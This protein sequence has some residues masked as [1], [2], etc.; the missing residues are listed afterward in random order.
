[1]RQ[2]PFGNQQV[3]ELALGTWGLA[4]DGYGPVASEEQDRVIDRALAMGI[5]LFETADVYGNG[6]MEKKLAQRLPKDG[7]AI[8]VTKVGTRR[9]NQPPLKDF[10][11]DYLRQAIE[12][13]RQRLGGG[14]LQCVLLHN[15][16]R[17]SF[18]RADIGGFMNELRSNGVLSKWGASIGAIDAGHSA[19]SAGAEVLEVPYNAFHTE[20]LRELQ[21]EIKARNVA[22]LARS[23]LAH[24]LLTGLWPQ[25]KEFP[26]YD[27]RAERWNNDEL[28]HRLYQVGPLRT[29]LNAQLTSIR[30]VALRFVL[31]NELV[32][33]VV[34][35][36]R[37]TLQLDQLVR[38]AGRE[39]PYLSEQNLSELRERLAT[40]G[41]YQ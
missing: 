22:V 14:P 29:M 23:V 11:L 15:P 4:G 33:S 18:D 19:L 41:V 27:H 38:E 10:S 30:S 5:R 21:Y 39:P 7:S 36:P 25:H 24:G 1:M 20:E 26:S 8:V 6:E 40:V 12:A 34:L 13:S 2:R 16:S 3:T 17:V 35:G 37:T 28:R 9:D 31:S 32:S